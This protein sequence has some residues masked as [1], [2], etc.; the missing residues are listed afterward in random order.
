LPSQLG[1]CVRGQQVPSFIAIMLEKSR[2]EKLVNEHLAGTDKFL[3]DLRVS[4]SN[5]IEIYIDGMKGVSIKDCVSLSR[6]VEGSL[7]REAE[8]FEL[9]VSSPG[10]EEPFQV[11]EQYEKNKG[12]KVKIIT[13]DGAEYTGILQGIK[14]NDV[15]VE[16]TGKKPSPTGKGKILVTEQLNLELDKV[17]QARVILSFK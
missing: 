9:D 2:I 16:T 11:R 12:R 8:D 14:G 4:P 13:T 3:V 7:D 6:H 17:K 10:A 1:F 15:V 5:K